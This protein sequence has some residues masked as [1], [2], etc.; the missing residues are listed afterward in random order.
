M[1]LQVDTTVQN[2]AVHNYEDIDYTQLQQDLV[3]S[4]RMCSYSIMWF[5]WPVTTCTPV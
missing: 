1:L 4:I 2:D 3:S 5:R